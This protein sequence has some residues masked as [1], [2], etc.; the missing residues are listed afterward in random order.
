[1]TTS[2][3]A[4]YTRLG[5]LMAVAAAND[6]GVRVQIRGV[7]GSDAYVMITMADPQNAAA[8]LD[9][10]GRRLAHKLRVRGFVERS[11]GLFELETADGDFVYF[12]QPLTGGDNGLFRPQ[13]SLNPMILRQRAPLGKPRAP[14]P[15]TE[16]ASSLTPYEQDLTA[17]VAAALDAGLHFTQDVASFVASRLPDPAIEQ[18]LPEITFVTGE[19][20]EI[21]KARRDKAIADISASPRGTLMPV[22]HDY[23][24]HV[25]YQ[26][27]MSD[28]MGHARGAATSGATWSNKP[29]WAEVRD[30]MVS[31]EIS[32]TRH[33]IET[34]RQV[35]RNLEA[36]SALDL[37]VGSTFRNLKL[38]GQ[39]ASTIRATVVDELEGR[40]TL[41]FTKRGSAHLYSTNLNA[42]E[43]AKLLEPEV[44]PDVQ[45]D[46]SLRTN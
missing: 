35:A 43:L 31:G 36:I 37:K 44:K 24:G 14:V 8:N 22:R 21:V 19:E 23:D 28:G 33:S 41:E 16:D 46:N 38:A 10:I 29:S 26:A 11:D 39:N 45:P 30:W 15:P 12:D 4:R 27:L 34:K 42:E 3:L 6:A 7:P 1:M 18:E 9:R 32:T 13:I 2:K 25:H 5:H 20:Y 17:A 40:V